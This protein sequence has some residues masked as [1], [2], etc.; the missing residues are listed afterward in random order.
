MVERISILFFKKKKAAMPMCLP[1][2]WIFAGIPINNLCCDTYPQMTTDYPQNWQTIKAR[3]K[4]ASCKHSE[5]STKM[6]TDILSRRAILP[7]SPRESV[8]EE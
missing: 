4:H 5:N 7:P 1:I 6:F 8:W 3:K 2:A